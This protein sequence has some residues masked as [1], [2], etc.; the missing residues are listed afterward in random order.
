MTQQTV[1]VLPV[2]F[3]RDRLVVPVLRGKAAVDKI[4]LLH[5]TGSGTDADH[6][7]FAEKIAELVRADLA[8]GFPDLGPEGIEDRW[9]ENIHQFDKAYE[10][11][12]D[13]FYR[14]LERGNRLYVNI[15]SMPRPTSFAL[16]SAA[17]ALVSENDLWRDNI[18]V[19]YTAPTEYLVTKIL[20]VLEE[21]KDVLDAGL[22]SPAQ[23]ALDLAGVTALAQA[24]REA[25][26]RLTGLIRSKGSTEGARAMDGDFMVPI[27]V[28]SGAKPRAF[29][30][31]LLTLLDGEKGEVE[32][33]T[34]L[35]Q[36]YMD[37]SG[38]DSIISVKSKV[39]YNIRSLARKG[40]VTLADGA[41]RSRVVQLTPMA[42]AWLNVRRESGDA[43]P[44][45]EL[46]PH[47]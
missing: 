29:E 38:E 18:T 44:E 35:A 9:V 14:E 20:R 39:I 47:Q 3:D 7:Q 15:S 1:H 12:Y 30:E 43:K 28:A 40:F 13:L 37:E 46:E 22:R 32:S 45:I 26:G 41:G 5:G 24:T 10:F 19:Y 17:S 23:G 11:A 2:G 42:R 6:A 8:T 36:I 21:Q 25:L 4:I 34:R 27:P 31:R 33:V 16:A